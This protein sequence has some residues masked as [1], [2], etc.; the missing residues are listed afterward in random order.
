MLFPDRDRE[1]NARS[2]PIP[3]SAEPQ[4]SIE[5]ANARAV[6]AR[7]D[8]KIVGEMLLGEIRGGRYDAVCAAAFAGFIP[9]EVRNA[10]HRGPA[11]GGRG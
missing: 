5:E 1:T 9:R 3:E 2:H 4:L 11:T 8:P 7:F 10:R 6:R